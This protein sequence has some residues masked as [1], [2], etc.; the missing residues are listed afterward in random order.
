MSFRTLCL[1]LAAALLCACGPGDKNE[2]AAGGDAGPEGK[3][4]APAGRPEELLWIFES[5]GN[6][7]CE[8]GGTTLAKSGERL[9]AQGVKVQESRCGVRTD[10]AYPSVCG[11]QTGDILLH[12]INKNSLDAALQLGF[13]PAQPIEYQH[14]DCPSADR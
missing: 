6:M 10:R 8:G 1:L 11:G 2:P 7:Q 9:S 4:Q 14:R 12:L 13:D 5:R 3:T